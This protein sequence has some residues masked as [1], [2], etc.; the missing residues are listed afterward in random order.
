MAISRKIML[1]RIVVYAASI[2]LLLLGFL[3]GCGGAAAQKKKPDFFTSGSK[4][5]DQGDFAG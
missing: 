3:A 2:G 1:A 4:E 5:A